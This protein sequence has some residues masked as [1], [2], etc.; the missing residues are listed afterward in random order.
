MGGWPH[1]KNIKTEFPCRLRGHDPQLS[2]GQEDSQG[3]AKL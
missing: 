2:C 1:T 3:I